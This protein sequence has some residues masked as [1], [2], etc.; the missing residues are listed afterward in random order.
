MDY[1]VRLLA[2]EEVVHV[3]WVVATVKGS[4]EGHLYTLQCAQVDQSTAVCH[5]KVWHSYEKHTSI[6][7]NKIKKAAFRLSIVYLF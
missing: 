6:I 5:I 3:L 7:C 4:G 2:Y 1:F